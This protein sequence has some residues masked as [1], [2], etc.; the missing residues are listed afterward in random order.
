MA[1]GWMACRVTALHVIRRWNIHL[2]FR[3]ITELA[4]QYYLLTHTTSVTIY[5][6]IYIYIIHTHTQGERESRVFLYIYVVGQ[7]Y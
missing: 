5:V 3:E 4:S 1:A 2:S 6:Q 7:G